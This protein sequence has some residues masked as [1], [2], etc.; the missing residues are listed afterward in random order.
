MNFLP[1]D[2]GNHF[3]EYA[4]KLRVCSLGIPRIGILRTDSNL[5]LLD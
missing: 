1:Y 2:I 5:V 4:G 3:C